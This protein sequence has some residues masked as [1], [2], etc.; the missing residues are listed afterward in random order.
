M[1][2]YCSLTDVNISFTKKLMGLIEPMAICPTKETVLIL[3]IV[4]IK[5]DIPSR[6]SYFTRTHT[7]RTTFSIT[8]NIFLY[9]P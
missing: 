5:I 9:N 8:H 4:I 7:N 2:K 6:V 1:L 3:C